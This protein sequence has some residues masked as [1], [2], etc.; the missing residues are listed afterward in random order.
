MRCRFFALKERCTYQGL[1][2]CEHKV[3]SWHSLLLQ[4]QNIIFDPFPRLEETCVV[5]SHDLHE[6]A[7]LAARATFLLH[8]LTE[9]AI[10]HLG[11]AERRPGI[12]GQADPSGE[13]SAREHQRVSS[14]YTTTTMLI[15]SSFWCE[16]LNKVLHINIYTTYNTLSDS[17]RNH[18]LDIS[19]MQH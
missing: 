2:S 11:R 18:H 3:N 6:I 10:I 1:S 16:V 13:G 7:P 9:A 8:Y 19:N 5:L 17:K 4:K 12:R 14:L 15:F